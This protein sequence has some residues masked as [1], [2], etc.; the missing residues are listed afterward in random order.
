MA[1][2]ESRASLDIFARCRARANVAC[3]RR[4]ILEGAARGCEMVLRRRRQYVN[5]N[6]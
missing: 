6:A 2:R 1:F 5:G 3:G 4:G